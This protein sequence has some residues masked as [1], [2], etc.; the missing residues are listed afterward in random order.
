M[1]VF[2]VDGRIFDWIWGFGWFG[3]ICLVSLMI[4]FVIKFI[5][6]KIVFGF[7]WF[8]LVSVVLFFFFVVKIIGGIYVVFVLDCYIR[9]ICCKVWND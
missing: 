2:Y 6:G 9:F 5:L 7:C 3:V 8:C 4:F 1:L